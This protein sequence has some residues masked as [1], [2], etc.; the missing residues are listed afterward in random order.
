M[1]HSSVWRVGGW[2]NLIQTTFVGI[3]RVLSVPIVLLLSVASGY[4]TYYGLS[5]FITHWIALTVTVAVQSIIVISSLELASIHYRANPLRFLSV[6]I[7]LTVALIVS[8]SFSYFKF[9]EFSERDT[10]LM[11]RQNA[12]S[13]EISI[14]LT[15]VVNL[16]SQLAKEQ[17]ERIS[18][19]AQDT[20]Q[21]FLSAHPGMKGQGPGKGRIWTYFNDIQQR[22]EIK[23]KALEQ[24]TQP[25]DRAIFES[26][27]ALTQLAQNLRDQASYDRFMKAFQEVIVESDRLASDRG[28]PPISAPRIPSFQGLSK[29]I[30]PTID[31]WMDISWFALAC[32]AMVDFFTLVLSY[33]LEM[34][35]PGPLSEEEKNLAY[36]G[37]RQ[38][39]HFTINQNDELEFSIERTELERARRVPDWQRMFAVAFLLNRGYLRKMSRHTVEF[40]PN[41]YPIIAARIPEESRSHQG[42]APNDAL[43]EAMHRKFHD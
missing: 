28:Q 6:V 11:K 4:T 43:T 29:D 9:Y 32:A 13:N 17:H 27:T 25:L 38:F 24:K 10:V 41:L 35:A 42:H 33:R 2:L 12:L 40:A 3:L 30:T 23:L 14:Y 7:S 15:E 26:R 37:L 19:A 22:E 5:F 16:K 18:G 1:S 36:L 31:M 8:V 20:Q 21:A 34:T 39:N